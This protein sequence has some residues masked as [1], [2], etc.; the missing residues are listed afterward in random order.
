MPFP[1]KRKLIYP[2]LWCHDFS[3][4]QM[5][6]SSQIIIQS[7][8]Q[9]QNQTQHLLS[10]FCW[11]FKIKKS[12]FFLKLLF[13]AFRIRRNVNFIPNFHAISF[14]TEKCFFFSSQIIMSGL[15]QLAKNINF[16]TNN[17]H[18]FLNWKKTSILSQI[19][20]S[21]LF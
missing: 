10:F 7:L 18:A 2:K 14:P 15:Y 3:T 11:V 1:I 13:R 17:H 12:Y 4:H 16:S 9:N 20:M 21:H 6:F 5:L 8:L 19:I